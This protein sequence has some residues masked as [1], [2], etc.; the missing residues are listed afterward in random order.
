MALVTTNPG[1]GANR[2]EV[3]PGGA[4]EQCLN[5]IDVSRATIG[6]RFLW[7]KGGA[8]ARAQDVRQ[9]LPFALAHKIIGAGSGDLHMPGQISP[10]FISIVA[11]TKGV[12][13]E[14]A[15]T[16]IGPCVTEQVVK[17]CWATSSCS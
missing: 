1:R 8:F 2:T 15:G 9:H 17:C 16:S 4:G 6:T 5:T 3:S 13:P 11:S 7:R 14:C 10:S 12:V